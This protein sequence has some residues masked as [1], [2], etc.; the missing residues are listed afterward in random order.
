MLIKTIVLSRP[1]CG[2]Q[3]S[4]AS[5]LHLHPKNSG[6]SCVTL[7]Q[8]NSRPPL[9]GGKYLLRPQQRPPPPHTDREGACPAEASHQQMWSAATD[10]LGPMTTSRPTCSLPGWGPISA[11]PHTER[12]GVPA[13]RPLSLCH[14]CSWSWSRTSSSFFPALLNPDSLHISPSL[15]R[16]PQGGATRWCGYA[17]S[18]RTA[19][20]MEASQ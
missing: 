3:D 11:R 6:T 19:N 13:G 16:S 15:Q 1:V 4:A 12:T 10:R 7:S 14:S 17:S 18:P 2:L 8:P 9:H 5:L 20:N